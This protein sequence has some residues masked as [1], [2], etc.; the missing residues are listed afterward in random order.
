[1]IKHTKKVQRYKAAYSV[2][3]MKRN[4]VVVINLCLRTTTHIVKILAAVVKTKISIQLVTHL[5]KLCHLTKK[6][7]WRKF[8]L[9]LDE[10]DHMDTLQMGL[11]L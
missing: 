2:I 9:L 1:M 3:Q 6:R 5:R 11:L 4:F 7:K 8:L 10:E